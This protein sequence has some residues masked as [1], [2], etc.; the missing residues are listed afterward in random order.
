MRLL[1]YVLLLLNVLYFAW[2]RWIDVPAKPDAGLQGVAPLQLAGAQGTAAAAPTSCES[3]GPLTDAQ[4][5]AAVS[6]LLAA[7]GVTTRERQ[8]ERTV[9]DGFN[10]F[11]GGFKNAA[12]QQQALRKLS[13]AGINDAVALS[14]PG[15]E[16]QVS[17]GLFADENNAERRVQDVLGAGYTPKMEPR[18]HQLT[19]Q[20]LDA[21]G[22]AGRQLPKPTELSA[23]AAAWSECPNPSN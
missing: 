15:Q 11:I 19:V 4:A 23:P 9:D 10:V 2:A 5:A 16:L 17:A 12:S 3:F 20:W 18:H 6:K 22:P 13:Q 1:V 7:R 21:E 8:S 14:G